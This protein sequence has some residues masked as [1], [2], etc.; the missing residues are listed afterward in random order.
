VKVETIGVTVIDVEVGDSLG[1]DCKALAWNV[2]K[3]NIERL[4]IIIEPRK[5]AYR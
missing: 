4:G 2:A 1:V 5:G 3:C